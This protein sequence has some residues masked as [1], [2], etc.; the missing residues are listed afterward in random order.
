VGLVEAFAAD[1]IAELHTAFSRAEGPK[2]YVQNLV[3]AQLGTAS[4]A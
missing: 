3:A 2:T 1:G 4:G